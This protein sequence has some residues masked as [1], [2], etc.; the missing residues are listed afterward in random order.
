MEYVSRYTF[1]TTSDELYESIEDRKACTFDELIQA[2][3]KK[4]NA[5]LYGSRIISVQEYESTREIGYG[6]S[7]RIIWYDVK[8]YTLVVFAAMTLP[9]DIRWEDIPMIF[10]Q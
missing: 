3:I 4:M 1:T 5:E 6:T 8:V 7:D 9:Q 10:N 2:T